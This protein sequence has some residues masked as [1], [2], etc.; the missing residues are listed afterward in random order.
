[1]TTSIVASHSVSPSHRGVSWIR[2]FASAV[3][4]LLAGVIGVSSSVRCSATPIFVE[5][6]ITQGQYDLARLGAADSATYLAAFFGYPLG[7]VDVL[8]FRIIA[9]PHE[10]GPPCWIL[11]ATI[12]EAYHP[13]PPTPW[14]DR[15]SPDPERPP[16]TTPEPA[17]G[18]IVGLTLCGIV[19]Y[20][21]TYG[22]NQSAIVRRKQ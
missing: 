19:A 7:N 11:D 8:D 18:A 9:E 6:V 12:D 4:V 2:P 3:L 13:S 20:S 15:P 14:A 10:D 17:S 16:T 5:T 1:M 22:R 21:K